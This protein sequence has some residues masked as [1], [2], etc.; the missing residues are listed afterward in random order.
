MCCRFLFTNFGSIDSRFPT[1]KFKRHKG[2]QKIS[3][4]FRIEKARENV[5]RYT[6]DNYEYIKNNQINDTIITPILILKCN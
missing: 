2:P 3:K 4:L 1:E 6:G 5:A